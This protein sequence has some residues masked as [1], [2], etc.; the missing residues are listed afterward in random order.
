MK[1][2]Q[3]WAATLLACATVATQATPIALAPTGGGNYAGMLDVA[4]DGLIIDDYSFT[5]E[6]FD[7]LVSVTLTSLSGPI[8]FFTAAFFPD[9]AGEI[10]FSNL[11][12]TVGASFSYA[13]LVTSAMP[14]TMRIFGAVV[15][16]DG[17]LG[18]SGEYRI[19]VT[20][21]VAAVPEPGTYALLLAG[22][23]GLA[24]AARQRRAVRTGEQA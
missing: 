9:T 20:T 23:F 19:A 17:N 15:D 7:G 8:N 21:Q 16:A 4:A 5:P 11:S 6:S 1:T 22:L 18:G 12:D 13:S 14:L 24:Y 10:D 3:L 2:R